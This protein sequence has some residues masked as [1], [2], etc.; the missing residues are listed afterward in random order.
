MESRLDRE[1][2]HFIHHKCSRI[3]DVEHIVDRHDPRSGDDIDWGIA[4][5]NRRGIGEMRNKL[6]DATLKR[7]IEAQQWVLSNGGSPLWFENIENFKYVIKAL[8]KEYDSNTKNAN[9]SYNRK[10]T[11]NI[12]TPVID[13]HT[14]TMLKIELSRFYRDNL[15]RIVKPNEIKSV[16]KSPCLRESII[17]V[18]GLKRFIRQLDASV[19]EDNYG[20]CDADF[21][22][23]REKQ[24]A[25]RWLLQNGASA[26]WFLN[27]RNSEYIKSSLLVKLKQNCD[28]LE[29]LY[30]LF[31]PN[32]K[33]KEKEGEEVAK[34]LANIPITE[35]DKERELERIERK[36]KMRQER[37]D[38]HI[39][40]YAM[41]DLSKKSRLNE[42]Q[43]EQDD[44]WTDEPE[45]VINELKATG[46]GLKSHKTN[47]L[48]LQNGLCGVHTDDYKKQRFNIMKAHNQVLWIGD[49]R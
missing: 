1:I 15:Q 44:E 9:D 5:R 31:S 35:K 10:A 7:D 30:R 23:P 6:Q 20:D 32:A 8:K 21:V 41:M 40:A 45:N 37:E 46:K 36:T 33:E 39:V 28:E 38:K 18:E 49:N 34:I 11:T 14:T 2:N 22:E 25:K 19:V 29:N 12:R 4:E 27:E 17:Q 16:F 47:L 42:E 26:S 48:N 24:F 13:E 43:E 3:F